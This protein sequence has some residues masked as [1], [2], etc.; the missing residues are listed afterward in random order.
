MVGLFSGG[1]VLI[2]RKS[3]RLELGKEGR[4]STYCS[5]VLYVPSFAKC[6]S[7]SSQVQNHSSNSKFGIGFVLL[8]DGNHYDGSSKSSREPPTYLLED[9]ET[10]NG[11]GLINTSNVL[12]VERKWTWEFSF[13][14]KNEN[15]REATTFFVQHCAGTESICFEGE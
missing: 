7:D 8:G 15:G 6:V 2:E 4:R 13:P 9:P 1:M 5:F 11:V 10:V 3:R 14:R 12:F